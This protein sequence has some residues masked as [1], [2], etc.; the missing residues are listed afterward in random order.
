M[1]DSQNDSWSRLR[2]ILDEHLDSEHL[3]SEHLDSVDENGG[4]VMNRLEVSLFV[5]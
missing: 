2:N 3:D 4:R 5:I 1:I